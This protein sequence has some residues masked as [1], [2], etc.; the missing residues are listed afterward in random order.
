MSTLV[1]LAPFALWLL[2]SSVGRVLWAQDRVP[3]KNDCFI[4]H[5]RL[6]GKPVDPPRVVNLKSSFGE[7]SVPLDGGCFKVPSVMLAEKALDISF[8]VPGNALRLSAIPTGFFMGPWDISLEDKTFGRAASLPKHARAREACNVV[9]HV[10][11]PE[12]ALLVTACRRP[13]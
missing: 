4:I 8:T 7:R 3:Q 2:V 12:T 13:E 10:G 6:N 1:R 9:F 5:V 11:E